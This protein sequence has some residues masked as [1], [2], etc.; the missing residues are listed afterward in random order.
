[1]KSK[2]SGSVQT[3][4]TANTS[5]QRANTSDQRY[6]NTMTSIKNIYLSFKKVYLNPR[7]TLLFPTLVVSGSSRFFSP[8]FVKCIFN[9][10]KTS[11]KFL[12]ILSSV[13]LYFGFYMVIFFKSKYVFIQG[14][15][16]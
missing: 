2:K 8:V 15:S 14:L 9:T 1:M 11:L 10:V 16:T 4:Q 3:L 7:Q 5:L 6:D 12:L 13:F